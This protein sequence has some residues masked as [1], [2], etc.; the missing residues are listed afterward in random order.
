MAGAAAG[1]TAALAVAVLGANVARP[2][3]PD[4]SASVA[5]A[6]LVANPDKEKRDFTVS[7]EVQ[8]LYPGAQRELVLTVGNPHNFD[9]RVSSLTVRVGN[10]GPG[11]SGANVVPTDFTGALVVPGKGTAEQSV[12]VAMVADPPDA[13]RNATFPLTFGGSAEKQ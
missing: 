5:G 1:I 8:G 4:G 9:I 2:A 3:V 11:C 7:G 10:A 6:R 13:C 12:P